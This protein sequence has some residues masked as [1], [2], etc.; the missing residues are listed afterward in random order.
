MHQSRVLVETK[1]LVFVANRYFDYFSNNNV[2]CETSLAAAAAS[3]G[4]ADATYPHISAHRQSFCKALQLKLSE[5]VNSFLSN[6][7]ASVSHRSLPCDFLFPY[8]HAVVF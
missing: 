8:W 3:A 5:H 7:L 2:E 6:T 1:G 4:R